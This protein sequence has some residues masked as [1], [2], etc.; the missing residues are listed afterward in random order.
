MAKTSAVMG[1][2][3]SLVCELHTKILESVTKTRSTQKSVC[4]SFGLTDKS[5][6]ETFSKETIMTSKRSYVVELAVYISV[7]Q[8]RNAEKCRTGST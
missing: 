6:S 1:Y 8:L 2:F 3:F 7:A 4:N 5:R